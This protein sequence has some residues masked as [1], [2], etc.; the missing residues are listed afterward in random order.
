MLG[1][2][3]IGHSTRNTSV[4]FDWLKKAF[5]DSKSK[6]IRRREPETEPEFRPAKLPPRRIET[7]SPQAA[8]SSYLASKNSTITV[9]QGLAAHFKQPTGESRPGVDWAVRITGER[10]CVVLV[11]TYFSSS[12][13]QQSE[14]RA[15]A[16]RAI[17]FIQEK[18][19]RGWIPE[20]GEMLEIG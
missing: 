16:D 10:A 20:Q 9:E 17:H 13:P 4:M 19:E 6:H 11:R 8:S 12:P 1:R 7:S 15:M 14:K 18:L 2:I 5:G 3:S